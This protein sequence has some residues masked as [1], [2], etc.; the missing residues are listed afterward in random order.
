MRCE[1]KQI[2]VSETMECLLL[3]GRVRRRRFM[4]V[5]F[6]ALHIFLYLCFFLAEKA[7]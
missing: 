1:S 4:C 5:F 7:T 2:S 6:L 3:N